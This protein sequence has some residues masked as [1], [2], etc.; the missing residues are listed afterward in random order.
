MTGTTFKSVFAAVAFCGVCSIASTSNAQSELVLPGEDYTFPQ[1]VNPAT[2]GELSGRLFIPVTDGSRAYVGGA[3]IVMTYPDGEILRAQTNSS[4]Q[5]VLKSVRAGGCT[6]VARADGAFACIAVHIAGTNSPSTER[7][8][9]ELEVGAVAV[10]YSVLKTAIVRY[11]P[12]LGDEEMQPMP[13]VD[14]GSVGKRLDRTKFFRVLQSNGGVKGNLSVAGTP[15]QAGF[16][17]VFL[18]H[19]G[20]IIDRVLSDCDG[21]FTF[22][23]VAPG[24]YGLMATGQAGLGVVGFELV[25]GVSGATSR[26]SVDST[27][28]TLVNN[29]IADDFTSG[30]SM[31]MASLAQTMAILK[32]MP[33]G[34]LATDDPSNPAVDQFGNPIGGSG[35]GDPGMG[36]GAGGG[37]S[38]GGGGF[39]GGG[40]GGGGGGFGGG[41]GGLAGIAAIAAIAGSDN[42]NDPL[43]TPPLPASPAR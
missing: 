41:L 39:G 6:L 33:E 13:S 7:L 27:E 31:E 20:G 5:F 43:V 1:W 17:N 30:F 25:S 10:D 36:G 38:A 15:S 16:V 40:S 24:E 18:L 34:Q 14:W 3:S 21:G 9:R 32:E 23:G 4:G 42:D 2:S 19:E 11:L 28:E 35:F 37:G 26:Y 22:Q 12:P 29:L 8:P